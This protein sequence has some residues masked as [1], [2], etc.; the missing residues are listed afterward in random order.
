CRGRRS[1]P[2]FAQ[3]PEAFQQDLALGL[4]GQAP[5]RGVGAEPHRFVDLAVVVGGV[6]V[7]VAEKEELHRLPHALP[8][9]AGA[10]V[11]PED[12]RAELVLDDA[13]AAGLL[14]HL[15]PRRLLEGLGAAH[16]ALGE[17]PAARAAR[18]DEA[19]L[20][21]GRSALGVGLGLRAL[22]P[23]APQDTA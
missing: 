17:L 14:A 12:D 6:A 19:D 23:R 5:G 21:V 8:L 18:R 13:V 20:D 11:E 3:L 7:L 9:G 16:V 22:G 2:S 15:A 4:E 1:S 10:D